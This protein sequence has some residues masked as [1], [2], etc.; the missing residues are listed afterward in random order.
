LLHQLRTVVRS[1]PDRQILTSTTLKL[2]DYNTKITIEPP[3]DD[4][5][6]VLE[7]WRVY[8]R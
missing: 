5:G 6:E 3:L 8:E 1:K 2:Y 4:N 7:G